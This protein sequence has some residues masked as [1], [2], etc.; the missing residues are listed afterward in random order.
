ML[1]RSIRP[2]MKGLDVEAYK[3]AINRHNGTL[4]QFMD[5][6]DLIRQTYQQTFI[7]AVKAIQKEAGI[8]Q[9]GWVG[10]DT[11]EWLLSRGWVDDYALRLIALDAELAAPKMVRPIPKGWKFSICQ[12]LHETGGVPGN[13]AMDWCAAPNTPV[14]APEP[15]YVWRLSGHPPT[16]DTSDALG[17][18]GWTVY[19]E[20]KAGYR[21]FITHLGKRNVK[22]GQKINAGDVLGVI[23]DQRYR[24]DHAHC[25]VT[26]PFGPQDAKK[27]ITRVSLAPAVAV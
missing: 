21:Y 23:G 15:G 1:R 24:P 7:P 11:A 17:I 25:G 16:D 14:L 18:F 19:L 20:T 12:G 2:G 27:K 9:T 8:P 10:P 26:S 5:K 13:W 3:R 4:A 22:Q 6:S